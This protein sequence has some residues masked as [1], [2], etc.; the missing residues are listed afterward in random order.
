MNTLFGAPMGDIMRAMLVVF[1]LITAVVATLA[2]R[3]PLLVKLGLRNIPRRRAQTILIIVGLMLSTVII[4]SAFGTGDTVSYSIRSSSVDTLGA[5]DETVTNNAG[6]GNSFTGR[7][8]GGDAFFPAGTAGLIQSRL[9]TGN[10]IDGVMGAV[11]QTVPLVD[12][13]TGQTKA[14]MVLMG[15]PAVYSPGFGTLTTIAGERATLGQLGSHEVYLNQKAAAALDAHAGDSLRLFVGGRPVPAVLRAVLRS[16]DLVPGGGSA[17]PEILVPL[18][19]LQALTGLPGKVTVV[20]VSNRGDALGGAA[21]TATVADQ[22]RALLANPAQVR[23]AQAILRAPGTSAELGTLQQ[24]PTIGAATRQKLR[25][26]QAQ[27]RLPGQSVRLEGLLSDPAV[28]TALK[29][30]K[31]PAVTASLGDALAGI[32]AYGVQTVKQDALDTAD[33]VGSLF[34]T[35]FIVFGLFTIAAGIMLILLIFAMLAAERRPEM[36]MARAVGTKRRQLIEQFLFEGYI[37]DLGAA[38]VGVALGIVIGLGMVAVMASLFGTSGFVLQRHVEP[39]SLVVAFCLGALITFL[40]VV[41]SS[42]RVSRLNIV[43]AIRNVPEEGKA[44]EGVAGA[45]GRPLADLRQAA[46]R[47]RHLRVWGTLTALLAALWHTAGALRVF[48][49]RGPLLLLLGL[50]LLALGLSGKQEFP[51][52]LGSSLVLVGLAMLARWIL[53]ALHVRRGRCDRLGYSLAG[54]AL[55]AYWLLPFDALQRAG[56]PKMASGMEM[57]FLSGMML[58]LGAVW[59]VMFNVDLLLGTLMGVAGKLGHLGPMLKMAVTY[60]LQAKMRTGLTLAMFSLVIFTL[61]VM[62]VI[63]ASVEV[64]LDLNRDVGGYQAYGTTSA[65]NPIRDLAARIRAD[66]GLRGRVAAVGGIGRIPVGLRQPGQPGASWQDYRANVLDP[67]YLTSTRF[68]LHARATG[69]TSDRQVWEAVRTHPG[70]AVVDSSLVRFKTSYNFGAT[71]APHL[72]GFYYEDASFAPA[73]MEMRDAR[74]GTAI[75]LTVIGVLDQYS[76]YLAG[77]TA[78]V[79]TGANT[80]AATHDAPAPPDL[81]VFRIAPGQDVHRT[82]LA[83]GKAFLANGLDMHEAR[84]DHD[85]TQ[86]ASIAFDN[87]LVAFMGLG[88]MVG[89]AAL[90]LIATRSVVERHQQIGMLRAIGFRRGMVRG[91]FLLESSFVA[92]LGTVLGVVLGLVLARNI[93][94]D[95][96]KSS[97]GMQ[98]TVPWVQIGLIVLLAYVATLLTTFLPAWQASRVYP[99]EALRYE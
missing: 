93:V 5:I 46:G 28:I 6:A 75:P 48:V 18:D 39:R 68:A 49:V 31:A 19:R 27:V 14:R 71:S 50:P 59:V 63:L 10:D 57:F 35:L 21:L 87:L 2:L 4:T 98:L 96:S 30:I 24:S 47:A 13:T 41:V 7:G 22:L 88:L 56:L 72:Q 95:L 62:S 74:T 34:T 20:L 54:I 52:A 82:A 8:R 77:L 90:G 25:E 64:A 99:A 80:L 69:F 55:V 12:L 51:F 40:T 15:I 65:L 76:L 66:P 9:G 36:G 37:Y 84:A 97:P 86:A 94:I 53:L 33:V 85:D 70:Y 61:M 45:F 58:V 11:V 32:S 79:Y 83:L 16:G 26:L 73:R 81:Y 42:W 1:M 60:P 44:G 78:G 43:A 91:I 38:L 29:T 23:A 67:A 17:D 3:N 89:I 92:I